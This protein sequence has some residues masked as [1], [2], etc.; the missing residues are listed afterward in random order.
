MLQPAKL[1]ALGNYTSH[2]MGIW[3]QPSG[4]ENKMF[5]EDGMPGIKDQM[6]RLL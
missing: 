3:V 6:K 4:Q 1:N 2:E 5:A